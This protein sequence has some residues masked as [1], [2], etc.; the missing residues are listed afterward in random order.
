MVGNNQCSTCIIKQ[1]NCQPLI[2]ME[3]L[4]HFS[5]QRLSHKKGKISP[6]IWNTIMEMINIRSCQLEQ[7]KF[8][9]W[10]DCEI[11]APSLSQ[12][13]A[14]FSLLLFVYREGM[15]DLCQI[16]EIQPILHFQKITAI[17]FQIQTQILR[18]LLSTTGQDYRGK[19]GQ[20]TFYVPQTDQWWQSKKKTKQVIKPKA[21]PV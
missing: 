17:L 8:F 13:S 3:T 15:T 1:P 5:F 18:T 20:L 9:K 6:T 7:S 21:A 4:Y 11:F 10:N 16:K 12:F 2:K 19:L 14:M